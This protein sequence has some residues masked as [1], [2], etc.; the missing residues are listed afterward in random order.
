MKRRCSIFL[1]VALSALL[2]MGCTTAE[3]LKVVSFNV[4]LSAG[5]DGD[6]CWELRR[7]AAAQMLESLQPDL[8]GVQ[9]ALPDQ[10]K[11]LDSV[12]CR[13]GHIGVGRDN[14]SDEGEMMEVF[15]RLDRFEMLDSGTFWLS[16]TPDSCS[17]GW[18]AACRRTATWV[19]LK[20][21][22]SGR[23]MLYVNTHLDHV[24]SK[25][26]LCSTQLIADFIEHKGAACAVL[27]GD[28]NVTPDNPALEPLRELMGDARHDAPSTDCKMTY[29]AFGNT[30]YQ[31]VI[32]YVFYLGLT[33]VSFRTVDDDRGVPYVSD[34]YP[35]EA[36]FE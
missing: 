25:A 30:D 2:F 36:V 11:F 19:E 16:P 12:L 22:T 10:T 1:S 34:H 29:N 23:R 32:D 17:F 24:G 20:E 8:L 31:Q 33:P 28:M 9:E 26:R 35:V 18:D 4:R 6:N 7:E 5:D 13:Y 15:Y 14:G 27:T 3:P 21:R